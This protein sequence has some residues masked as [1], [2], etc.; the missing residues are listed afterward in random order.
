MEHLPS[1][2]VTPTAEKES[3]SEKEKVE[4]SVDIEEKL[5]DT[6]SLEDNI[7]PTKTVTYVRGEPIIEDGEDVSNFLVDVTDPGGR[8]LTFRSI[9]MGTAMAGFGASVRQIYAF[10]P[11]AVGV[12][13]VFLLLVI[14]SWGRVWERMPRKAS[15]Q[16]HRFRPLRHL[17]PI[18]HFI[19]PGNFGM[20]EHVVATLVATTASHGSTA[21]T[22]FA[23]QRLFYNE[24]PNA[25][26]AVMATFSTACFGYGMTGLLRPLSVYPSFMV[27]WASLPNV[28]VFQALHLHEASDSARRVKIFWYCVAAMAIYEV[29]PAYIFPLLNG[30]SVVCLATQHVAPGPR[31]VIGNIFGGANSNEGLG[32]FELS[33]DWQYLGSYWMS[34]P[35]GLQAPSWIGIVIS[36]FALLGM[37]YTNAWQAK[38]FPFLSTTLFDSTGKRWNQT[39]VFGN[40]FSL[41]ETAYE[42]IGQPFLTGG[43]ALFNMGQNWAI[44]ALIMHVL[45]FWRNDIIDS[46]KRAY[47][48]TQNDRHYLAMKKYPEAPSWWYALLLAL[49]FFAGL[50]VVLKGDTT[51]PVW[52]FVVALLVG[53]M[54][55]PF[56]GI[57]NGRLGN[58]IATQ[59]LMKMIAGAIHPGKPVAN[60]YF[61]MWSHDL[62]IIA[63]D[64]ATDLKMGQYLK[65]PPRVMFLTQ[66]YGTL[67][68]ALINYVVMVVITTN[69]KEILTDPIGDNVW[70]G[71]GLQAGNSD[72][73]TWSL[74]SR[75]YGIH[76]MY[77]WVPLGIIF[78][79]VAVV[80]QWIVHRRWPKIGGVV[81]K[82]VLLPYIFT[83]V[84]VLYAGI[85]STITST[86]LLGIFCQW[87]LRRR[88][89]I[90]FKKYNFLLG[91]AFD[92]GAQIT[93][94]VLTFAVFGASGVPRPFPAW[95]GN[96]GTGN[97]DYCL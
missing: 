66:V 30:V 90:W 56:S 83:N 49:S 28:T 64:L 16:N 69:K 29:F 17:A 87:W 13:S 59:Q 53:V 36:Y 73:I 92:G 75:V 67:L 50:I 10:K 18:M 80:F 72:A 19:N 3:L 88:Y 52:G 2:L 57:L 34:V 58:G 85:N 70:S 96:R 68:G 55:S 8:A 45:L 39:A 7:A 97:V 94:F 37:Y 42:I 5:S 27:Y 47:N 20:K 61:T 26:T 1:Q 79:A 12:S 48:G 86:V 54:I 40:S 62:V 38:S 22:N 14:Y 77:R 95:W 23:I 6:P 74:A 15:L 84:A 32:L 31:Q 91:G 4:G 78:G 44:G 35:L 76:S 65:I 41:N 25:V 46:F 51:L 63:V 89:P 82:Q 24:N 43:S 71:F 93:L 11:L 33:F 60:L 81:V 9:V 21:V